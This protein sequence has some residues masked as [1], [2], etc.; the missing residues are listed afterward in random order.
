[1]LSELSVTEKLLFTTVRIECELSGGAKS[2]G[3]GFFFNFG[4]REERSFPV[5]VTNK[6]VIENALRGNF[7]FT[8]HTDGEFNLNNQLN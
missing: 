8:I 4:K 6:H 5:I 1:M 7:K 2:L 3:S